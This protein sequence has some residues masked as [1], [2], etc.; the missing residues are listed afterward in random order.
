MT[1]L[2]QRMLKELQRRN[3]SQQTIRAYVPDVAAFLLPN[4]L[5]VRPI[6]LEIRQYQMFLIQQ[7]KLSWSS[8]K[9]IVAALRFFYTK[10]LKREFLLSDIPFTREPQKLP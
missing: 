9:Q 4:T 6:S 1:T 8:Y 3:Y 2:R 5:I 10:V 7:K